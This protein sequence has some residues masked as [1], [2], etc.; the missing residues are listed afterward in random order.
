MRKPPLSKAQIAA[1][2]RLLDRRPRTIHSYWLIGRS[3]N[4]VLGGRRAGYGQDAHVEAAKAL[5]AEG[6]VSKLWHARRLAASWTKAEAKRASMSMNQV[7]ALLTLDSTAR[8]LQDDGKTQAAD[9]LR[10]E[11]RALARTFPQDRTDRDAWTEWRAQLHAART[12][13]GQKIDAGGETRPLT[14]GRRFIANRLD[15]VLTRMR[16]LIAKQKERELGPSWAELV[17]AFSELRA[18]ILAALP[19]AKPKTKVAAHKRRR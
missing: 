19:K 11:R 9:A 18:S 8:L 4:E 1:V 16:E 10:N 13:Y 12:K 3:L 15:D 7:V 5:S 17:S 2:R 6:L 14:D